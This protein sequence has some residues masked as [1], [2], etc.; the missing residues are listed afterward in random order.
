MFSPFNAPL[1][2]KEYIGNKGHFL[3]FF[4]MYYRGFCHRDILYTRISRNATHY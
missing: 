3:S 2:K 1:F 4:I